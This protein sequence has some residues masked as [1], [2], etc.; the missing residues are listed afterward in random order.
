MARPRVEAHRL[1]ELVRLRRLGA[2]GREVVRLLRMSPKTECRYRGVL[3]EAGLLEGPPQELPSLAEIR[4][5]VEA[6]M[7]RA[8]PTPSTVEPW[9]ERV[10][11]LLDKGLTARAVYDRIRLDERGGRRRYRGSYS[12]V[13]RF[14]RRV[15][16]ERGADPEDVAVPIPTMPGLEGQIDFGYAGRLYDPATGVVRRAWVFILLCVHSRLFF[17]RLV[18]DQKTETWLDLHEQAFRAIGGVPATLIPDNTGRA[19]L[20][21][22]FGIDGPTELE[23]SYRELGERYGFKIDPA[24]PGEPRK[25]GKVEATVR[26]LRG[27]PLK[28][29]DGDPI[30]EVQAD[31]D[32]WNREVASVR[33]H[34]TT[35][36]RPIEVFEQE[37]RG[38]LLPLPADP[39]ERAI[40][41]HAKVHP[42]S[43]VTCRG[44]LFSVPWQLIHER[45]WVRACGS[46][47]EVFHQDRSVAVHVDRRQR[48]TTL[49]EHLPKDRGLLRHRSRA[50]WESR[51]RRIGPETLALA[52]AVFDQDPVLS[53]LRQVQA[54]VKHLEQF[55]RARAELA[56]HRARVTGDL[57]YRGIKRTLAEGL[58][59]AP[60]KE[61]AVTDEPVAQPATC[62][63]CGA[64][65][66]DTDFACSPQAPSHGALRPTGS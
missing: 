47:V 39:G 66:P 23:R 37:E 21:A 5:A 46:K 2:S 52:Q 40:W 27:N 44:R 38:A 22:A 19:V 25:R 41:K 63:V 60:V 33:V 42:D 13:K 49:E 8:G 24:P 58:D 48:R 14:V 57:S 16:R 12:A 55:P 3:E 65:R 29:R 15:K 59:L 11:E 36:R 54:I 53:Y 62:N 56:S 51:A 34:G 18:F 45:V 6:A 17:A 7:P 20:R 35:G 9:R 26:Y 43:H 61:E 64:H 31:L 4:A 10:E 1:R 50:F 32:L 28:G 30:D